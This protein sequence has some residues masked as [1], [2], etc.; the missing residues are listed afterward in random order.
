MTHRQTILA[1]AGIV[2]VIALSTVVVMQRDGAGQPRSPRRLVDLGETASLD[3]R[4][5]WSKGVEV[6]GAVGG[7]ETQ[8]YFDMAPVGGASSQVSGIVVFPAE[9][10]G[11]P[12][13]DTPIGLQGP[14]DEHGCGVQL[15]EL[16]GDAG[17]WQLR[18][19]SSVLI[20][21]T[22][23]MAEGRI[24]PIAF[25][26]VPEALCNG[27]G[28]WRTFSSPRWPI[29]FEYPANWVLTDDQD[30][31]NIECP[32]ITAL[33]AGGKWLT[34][35]RGRLAQAGSDEPY[36]FVK[37]ANDDWRV[38]DQTCGGRAV[39][40]DGRAPCAPARRSERNGMTVLQGAVGEH[41]LY[42]PGIGYLGK[43]SGITRYLF[44]FGDRW[45]SLDSA[46]INRHYD[47]IGA[48]GGP[49]LFEGDAVGER[50]VRSITL[51]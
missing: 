21:G 4:A 34:F 42:R 28:E 14:L 7:R 26:L 23:R 20:E 5:M 11:R 46:G 3:C 45:V 16:G 24:E 29:T 37:L 10:R 6:E 31:V 36:W 15:K 40:S 30:D 41:R 13:A 47:D 27:A 19:E 1:C 50:V 17:V 33:A 8:A 35:E 22:R 32:S 12:L 25:T 51:R 49:V 48:D 39:G 38:N 43:G 18:L 44:V 2:I 9:R